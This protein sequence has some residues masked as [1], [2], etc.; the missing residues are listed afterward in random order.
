MS[1]LKYEVSAFWDKEAQVWVAESKSVPSLA[2]EAKTLEALTQKLR[3]L[4]PELLQLNRITED[5]SVR[6][7]EIEITSH[8]QETIQI[9]I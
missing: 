9:A 5:T 6:E 2:T 3:T 7:I 4:V 1:Q 8:R